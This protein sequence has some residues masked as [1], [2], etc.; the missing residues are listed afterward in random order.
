MLGTVA[1]LVTGTAGQSLVAWGESAELWSAALS[2]Q[3]PLT[4]AAAVAAA[5]NPLVPLMLVRL[6]MH[7]QFRSDEPIT[8]V[9][10]PRWSK[11]SRPL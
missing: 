11:N 10:A 6:P 3:S 8:E 5:A 7:D 2:L 1:S 4:S 9:R